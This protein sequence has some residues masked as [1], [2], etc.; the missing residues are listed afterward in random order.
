MRSSLPESGDP[1]MPAGCDLPA[2]VFDLGNVLIDWS[3]HAAITAGVGHERATAFLADPGFDFHAWNAAQDAGR[4]WAEGER[5]ALAT[6]PHYREE[7]LAY[8]AHFGR[9][10]IGPIDGVVQLLREL[11]NGGVALFALTN[12]SRE[13]FPVAREQFDFLQLFEDI[14]V[15]GEEGLAKPDLAIFALLADRMREAWHV[16]PPVFVDDRLDN[17]VASQAA[18]MDGL[19]YASPEE[20]RAELAARGL[21][22]QEPLENPVGSV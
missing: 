10:L 3:A 7:I 18:G 15:S 11:H 20:L 1:V 9:S 13:L 12:W 22:G 14:V 4:T 6:H 2:V 5:T 17:V 16:A 21:V 19:L 8:R